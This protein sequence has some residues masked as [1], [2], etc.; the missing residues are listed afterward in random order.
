MRVMNIPCR[1]CGRRGEHK[2][3]TNEGYVYSKCFDCNGK[4]YTEAVVFSI[5]E[6]QAILKHCGLATEGDEVSE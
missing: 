4:G 2:F 1:S 3:F 5:E 6:A